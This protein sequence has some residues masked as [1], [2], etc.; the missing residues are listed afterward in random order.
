M[1]TKVNT[2]AAAA[3][4]R[5][6]QAAT[7]NTNADQQVLTTMLKELQYN[8]EQQN[9]RDMAFLELV[10]KMKGD[11]AAQQVATKVPSRRPA[12]DVTDRMQQDLKVMTIIGFAYK[13][14]E[15]IQ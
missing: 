3:A 15:R 10:E 6:Q 1:A 12:K 5:V 14:P 8:R 4:K 9:K 13:M 11:V 7:G 2:Q